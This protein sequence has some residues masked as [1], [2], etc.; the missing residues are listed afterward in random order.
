MS[1]TEKRISLREVR[2]NNLQGLDLEIPHGQ[3]MGLCGLSGAGKSS[4]ALDTLFAEGQRRYIESFSA[5]ARQFLAQ[6]ERPKAAELSGLPPAIAVRQ[7]RG[8]Y[9]QRSTVG[10]TTETIEYLRLLF[11]RVAE[12]VCPNCQLPVRRMDPV[13]LAEQI[14]SLPAGTRFMICFRIGL[15]NETGPLTEAER[16]HA[17]LTRLKKLGF[18]RALI[19]GRIYEREDWPDDLS[20]GSHTECEAVV[21]RLVA[22]RSDRQRLFDSLETAF[23][24]GAHSLVI[25]FQGDIRLRADGVCDLV[26]L[27]GGEWT[28]WRVTRNLSCVGCGQKFPE[29]DPR[30]FSFNDSLGACPV[31]EGF[32]KESFLD[33]AKIVPDVG[34]SIVSGAIAP[35]NTPSYRHELEELIALAGDFG[36]PVDVPFDRLTPAQRRLVWEGVPERKFGGLRGF[37]AGL[38]RRKYKLHVRVYAA[39]WRSYRDCQACRGGRLSPLALA[40]Q[41]AG[42]NMAAWS[43][44]SADDLQ[45]ACHQLLEK[46]PA[47]S[48]GIPVLDQLQRRIDYLHEVGLG[49]LSLDRPMATLSRGELQR[50]RLTGSLSSTLVNLLYVLEEPSIGLHPVDSERVIQAIDRLNSRGNTVVMI[51]HEW[52]YLSAVDRIVELGPESGRRGGKIEYDGSPAGVIRQQN[53]PTGQYLRHERGWPGRHQPPRS[54]ERWMT[55]RGAHGLHLKRV[56]VE[57][58][59]QCLV[60]VCGVSGSGKSTL[61]ERTL[62]PALCQ[63]LEIEAPAPLPFEGLT[64]AERLEQVNWIDQAPLPRSSRSNPVTY[65]KAFD[66]I[67]EV[68][69]ATAEAQAKNLNAGH[70]SF[71]LDGGRCPKCQGQGQLQID[72]QFL[73]DVRMVCDECQGTRYRAEIL[74]VKYRGRNIAEVLQLTVGDAFAFFRGQPGL[75]KLL[76]SLADVGL[77]YLQLGQS[78]ETMSSGESQRLKLAAQ[79][80]SRSKKRTLYLLDHPTAGLHP[81]DVVRLIDCFRSLVEV[82]HSVILIDHRPQI[83]GFADWL[84]ELGPGAEAAGGQI[85]AAGSPR[86]LARS[87]ETAT[88]RVLANFFS[89]GPDND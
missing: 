34:R 2:V 31:C 64:G 83:L 52:Q 12:I 38:D 51:D 5:A 70:F 39:R 74:T 19:S 3:W 9:G 71:N 26:G 20:I 35:W 61:V 57:F 62:W 18:A 37:F 22:G 86:D 7:L 16:G 14:E 78:A 42:R 36:L 59:L 55:L 49:Y 63:Q 65:I 58:P 54:P 43:A 81:V 48:A 24:S 6:I 41:V 73:A 29:A 40:Y 89:G 56:H 44:L 85:I 11:A 1:R 53:S 28:R 21:D 27:Q 82:G 72:M 87:S 10:T 50:T 4:L 69:A 13:A 15:E 33:E 80:G 75:Q 79:I 23:R 67:R 32:G 68:F 60:A 47:E 66:E 76:K 17:L 88:G 45:I 30:L 77:D 8:R 46:L 25:Y 84:I